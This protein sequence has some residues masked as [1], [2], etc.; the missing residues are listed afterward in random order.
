MKTKFILISVALLLTLSL[1]AQKQTEKASGTAVASAKLVSPADTLQYSLGVFVGQWMLNSGFAVSNKII[2]NQGMDDI[3]MNRP[4]AIADSAIVPIIAAYQ[5]S[6]Q[7]ERS[8]QMEVQLFA[9]L[10]EQKGVGVLPSGVHYIIVKPAQGVRPNYNDT[11]VFHA[12]GA[13]PDGTIFEDTNQKGLPITNLVSNLIPGLNEAVQLM[14]VGSTWRIFVPSALA[15]GTAGLEGVIP[16]D[17]A[18]V[19]EIGLLEVRR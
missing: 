4:R 2:F 17:M 8:R 18:V 11:I 12:V 5:L 16:G 9:D 13:F 7:N 6:T 3:M 14:P 10:K 19:F 15:Y 1:S